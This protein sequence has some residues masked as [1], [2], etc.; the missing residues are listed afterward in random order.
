MLG[1]STRTC[2]PV[3]PRRAVSFS[4]LQTQ[5]RPERE[6]RVICLSQET[7]SLSVPIAF[8]F[9][10]CITRGVPSPAPVLLVGLRSVFWSGLARSHG[11][12]GAVWSLFDAIQLLLKVESG[13]FLTMRP[14]RP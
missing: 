13:N 10:F 9:I 12:R 1:T 4:H 2:K 14:V 7:A 3:V 6:L 5:T 11:L 8:T